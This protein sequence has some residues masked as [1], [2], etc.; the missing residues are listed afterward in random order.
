LIGIFRKE[1]KVR[2]IIL[3]KSPGKGK[4]AAIAAGV[5]LAAGK[6]I[7][8]TDADCEMGPNWVT[9]MVAYY[10]E[11]NPKL[12]VGP[13]VYQRERSVIQK[14]FSLDFVSLVASG[15]GSVGAKHPFMGNGANLAFQQKV[16]LEADAAMPGKQFA[17]GDDVFLIQH[18]LKTFGHERVHFIKDAEVLVSTATPRNIGEFFWQRVRWGSKARGY[19]N[20][21]PVLVS[22]VVLLFNLLLAAAFAAGFF[23]P[24]FL[25]IY[26]LYILL[27]YLIDLPL[28]YDFLG[29]SDKRYL[30]AFVF[31][32]EF[33]YP[34]YIVATAI[35]SI[36]YKYEWKGRRGLR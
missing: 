36:F 1:N 5:K 25:P 17:S 21:W 15:A 26:L 33:V 6:L 35:I 30:R 11:H 29:F 18:I 28:L 13:V 32:F 14:F 8:T 4:K 7:L 2:N 19:R 3:E 23:L 27:K 12:I 16:F 31:P 34:F 22:W 20:F 9:H 10:M 24:W